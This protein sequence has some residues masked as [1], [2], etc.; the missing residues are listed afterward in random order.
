MGK[1]DPVKDRQ[2]AGEQLPLRDGREGQRGGTPP[3][4]SRPAE[5]SITTTRTAPKCATPCR[6][7]SWKPSKGDMSPAGSAIS[8]YPSG[9]ERSAGNAGAFFALSLNSFYGSF[10]DN[11]L[12]M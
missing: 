8:K 9:N 4:G 2:Y 11:L 12:K 10:F 5:A 1:E 7:I 3:S 6:W